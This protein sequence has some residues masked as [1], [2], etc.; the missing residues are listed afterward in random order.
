MR[1]F[2]TPEF[3]N[4]K[5]IAK[6]LT[7]F[8]S[9]YQQILILKSLNI[10]G[11]CISQQKTQEAVIQTQIKRAV[12]EQE[13]ISNIENGQQE[14]QDIIE[15]FEPKINEQKREEYKGINQKSEEEEDKQEKKQQKQKTTKRDENYLKVIEYK[16]IKIN[17]YILIPKNDEVSIYYDFII[18][19]SHIDFQYDIKCKAI[20]TSEPEQPFTI[21]PFSYLEASSNSSYD[22]FFRND[23]YFNTD[24]SLNTNR[25][26]FDTLLEVE[27][28]LKRKKEQAILPAAFQIRPLKQDDSHSNLNSPRRSPKKQKV[29]VQT[30]V[31]SEMLEIMHVFDLELCPRFHQLLFFLMV[32]QQMP[33]LKHYL[34]NISEVYFLFDQKPSLDE[35]SVQKIAIFYEYLD[36]NLLELQDYLIKEKKQLSHLLFLKLCLDLTSIFYNCYKA[37]TYRCN[38]TLRSIYYTMKNRKF[39]L[40]AFARLQTL[41]RFSNQEDVTQLLQSVSEQKFKFFIKDF[42]KDF[43]ALC[44]IILLFKNVDNSIGNIKKIR[45]KKKNSDAHYQ[46]YVEF[47]MNQLDAEGTDK[48]IHEL[49]RLKCQP[50]SRENFDY[51]LEEIKTLLITLEQQ[52]QDEA[53]QKEKLEDLKEQMLLQNESII[54]VNNIQQVDLINEED[55]ELHKFETRQPKIQKKQKIKPNEN[56]LFNEMKYSALFYFETFMER[57][58]QYLLQCTNDA[59][60]AYA[61]ILQSIGQ[62]MNIPSREQK[63]VE[64]QLILQEASKLVLKEKVFLIQDSFNYYLLLTLISS[65]IDKPIQLL[66][67]LKSLIQQQNNIRRKQIR[68]KLSTH[69]TCT[70]IIEMRKALILDLFYIDHYLKRHLYTNATQLVQHIITQQLRFNLKSYLLYGRSLFISGIICEKMMQPVSSMLNLEVCRLIYQQFFPVSKFMYRDEETNQMVDVEYQENNKQYKQVMIHFENEASE[71]LNILEFNLGLVYFS[72]SDKE[73]ALKCLRKVK[74]AREKK[75]DIVSDEVLE[76]VLQILKIHVEQEENGAAMEICQEYYVKFKYLAKQNI[77]TKSRYIARLQ[78]IMAAIYEC[79]RMLVSALKY[80]QKANKTFAMSKNNSYVR[81]LHIL[82]KIKK[83]VEVIKIKA[84]QSHSLEQQSE[85]NIEH[86][87]GHL[88]ERVKPYFNNQFIRVLENDKIILYNVNLM[89]RYVRANQSLRN[90]EYQKALRSYQRIHQ[91]FKKKKVDECYGFTLEKIGTIY[92]I[93]RNLKVAIQHLK[94]ASELHD[95]YLEF[96]LKEMRILTCEIYTL[97]GWAILKNSKEIQ[98]QMALIDD[99]IQNINDIM[100]WQN[101]PYKQRSN[102]FAILSNK[103]G[104][105]VL[106]I[107]NDL[108]ER[109]EKYNKLRIKFCQN[110]NNEQFLSDISEKFINE[111]FN[112]QTVRNSDISIQRKSCLFGLFSFGKRRQATWLP[113]IQSN[114]EINLKNDVSI[115]IQQTSRKDKQIEKVSNIQE[116]KKSIIIKQTEKDK[117]IQQLKLDRPEIYVQLQE[118]DIDQKTSSKIKSSLPATAMVSPIL[119]PVSVKSP[120]LSKSQD[121]KINP[122]E[123]VR[124]KK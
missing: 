79:N 62:T 76:V 26:S 65:L 12:E 18:N 118:F 50:I 119:S 117:Y 29:K 25:Q 106:Y 19:A 30:E 47:A 100:N 8:M 2:L 3:Q 1:L 57:S 7:C 112:Q 96:P 24:Q 43:G 73:N 58:Q 99:Y 104:R 51:I 123:K 120:F 70:G 114:Q 88:S 11:C 39:K 59:H 56:D 101:I 97:L 34:V 91:R 78:L 69:H 110:L 74:E 86:Y 16:S 31:V 67:Q 9:D 36:Y 68:P 93:Q 61:L 81:Q 20:V 32:Q 90:L 71:N 122:F 83:I 102:K 77:L 13:E 94:L 27:R 89:K 75:Y 116:K 49:I 4:I 103:L 52:I 124:R 17:Y 38:F 72:L 63:I 48:L 10:M 14:C 53:Q 44:D 45:R 80:Y 21:K 5:M 108:F 28:T 23:T 92:L 54:K 35:Q 107:L 46:K 55:N 109:I 121:K 37:F 41:I 66:N 87:L 15:Q 113:G 60:R 84:Y 6:L 85:F 115:E 64:Q 40:Q 95:R 111:K 105:S 98:K 82:Q 33:K 22:I 42:E